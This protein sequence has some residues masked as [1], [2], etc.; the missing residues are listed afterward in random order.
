MR[1]TCPTCETIYEVPSGQLPEGGR[2]V[3]CSTCHTRWF[4]RPPVEPAPSE[5]QI[6]YRLETRVSRTAPVVAGTRQA[7]PQ[8]AAEPVAETAPEPDAPPEAAPLPSEPEPA[9]LR[10]P[11]PA[12]S[13]QPVAEDFVWEGAS[14]G[15]I[16]ATPL[17]RSVPTPAAPVRI[18]PSEPPHP[19]AEPAAEV[20]AHEERPAPPHAPA[21]KPA[22]EIRRG[23]LAP[24]PPPRPS[25]LPPRFGLSDRER[26]A[27]EVSRLD[28]RRVGHHPLRLEVPG[29]STDEGWDR[30]GRLPPPS[31][32]GRG[33][34]VALLIF[35]GA[36][37]LYG[38]ESIV[39]AQV[40]ALA[41]AVDAYVGAIDQVREALAPVR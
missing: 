26:P 6:I 16:R 23:E 36:L 21:P 17:P 22:A 30:E 24:P 27:P 11:S 34:M 41:P 28:G 19:A 3:Q 7:P 29:A 38:F 35:A 40:P 2:H 13:A 18:R 33:V 9:A 12:P 10:D 15:P 37:A 8:P 14:P 20:A 31:R 1:L 25:E 4:A 5:D 39:V 32:F